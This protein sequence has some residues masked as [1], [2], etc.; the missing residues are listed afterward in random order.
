MDGSRT[1]AMDVGQNDKVSD[2]MNEFR[3][4]RTCT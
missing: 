3:A 4:V 1:I 2:M